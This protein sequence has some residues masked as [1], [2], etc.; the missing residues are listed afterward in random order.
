MNCWRR[1]T[2]EFRRQR[3]WIRVVT[4]PR[5]PLHEVMRVTMI[6]A[7][8][9]PEFE[10][11]GRRMAPRRPREATEAGGVAHGV[12]TSE[13]T[14]EESGRRCDPPLF[15][16]ES[17]RHHSGTRYGLEED[18]WRYLEATA[19]PADVL[20]VQFAFSVQHFGGDAGGSENVHEVLLLQFVRQH[21][22]VQN[23][24]G[25]GRLQ[26][27]VLLFEVFNEESLSSSAIRRSAA[28][29]RFPLRSSSSSNAMCRSFS[30]SLR[31]T[32]GRVA[33]QKGSI[34]RTD[35]CCAHRF[36]PPRSATRVTRYRKT[37]PTLAYSF[38]QCM[39]I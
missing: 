36:Q 37:N 20:G 10:L 24:D 8:P 2:G 18:L 19:Q 23:L 33:G 28:L 15:Y 4:A 22:F 6:S 3:C 26:D 27:V 9:T 39:Y 7:M 34:F 38:A 31:M 30:A 5:T 35:C 12:H 29:I 17:S 16:L 14:G 11:C 32:A 21:Q 13:Y 25:A 1:C